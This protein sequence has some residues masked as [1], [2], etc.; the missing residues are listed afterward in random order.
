LPISLAQA[1]AREA[2]CDVFKEAPR[3]GFKAGDLTV[4]YFVLP[5]YNPEDEKRLAGLAAGDVEGVA[6]EFYTTVCKVVKSWD[7]LGADGQP[8]QI[9]P[10]AMIAERVPTEL[11]QD[12]LVAVGKHKRPGE[13]SARGSRQR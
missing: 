12:I 13:G 6:Q 9:T 3:T 10:E 1:L 8:I 7:L 4:T 11:L 5:D 2:T